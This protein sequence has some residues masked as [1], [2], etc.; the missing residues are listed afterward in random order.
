MPQ[1]AFP[2]TTTQPQLPMQDMS[3]LQVDNSQAEGVSWEGP[4]SGFPAFVQPTSEDWA[5]DMMSMHQS[6]PSVGAPGSHY[7]SVSSSGHLTE[8]STPDFL[9]IQQF[10]DASD[11]Q[12][13]PVLGK[14]K[15]EDELVGMG[16]YTDPDTFLEG[17]L[18]GLN[19]K[20]LK[21]EE[22]FTP[23]SDD[24]GD[25]NDAEGDQDEPNEMHAPQKQPTKPAESM[26]HKSFFF[27]DGDDFQQR[28]IAESRH[29]FNIGA[30]CMNYGYGWV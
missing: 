20:G 24:E 2:I 29:S 1:Q 17:S 7:E 21:L 3:F 22:T 6:I 4:A 14:Q 13:V 12:S 30:T 5:F 10:G 25:D 9:P 16:L 26:M 28:S 19:G 23:S 15:H 18:N 11:S 27:D 8:P